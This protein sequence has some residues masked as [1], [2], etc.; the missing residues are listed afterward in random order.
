MT[1]W[2]LG[3]FAALDTETDG[4]NPR[5][6]RIVTAAVI[7]CG[8]GAA[9]Q[10]HTWLLKPTRPI[11]PET[12]A[13]HGITTDQATA[14]GMDHA[15]AVD[16]IA[17][18][19][20]LSIRAGC[21]VV[22]QNVVYDLTVLAHEL[23]RH[24]LPS[25]EQRLGGPVQPVIDTLVLDKAL[26]RYRKGSR[27]LDALVAHYRVRLDGAHDATLD[28]LA[29]ARVAWRI[30]TLGVIAADEQAWEMTGLD[31][32]LREG[33]RRVAA[34]SLHELHHTQVGWALEQAESF[35]AYRKRKGE[36]YEDITGEWPLRPAA[37]DAA[38]GS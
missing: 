30:G 16:L 13:I 29:A 31:E 22:G 26:D 27:K 2:H 19:L 20:C 12:T 7:L 38:V 9:T 34:M 1:G 33:Y 36:P 6:A 5:D 3:R 21:P 35:R 15:T 18:E 4:V 28:A 25:L 37:S 24:E 10:S 11:P 23:A 32:K 14:D 17:A 8:N